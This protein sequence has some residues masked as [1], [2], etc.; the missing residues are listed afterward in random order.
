MVDEK[1]EAVEE[2]SKPAPEDAGEGVQ[3]ETISVLDRSDQIAQM[4]KRENDRREAILTREEELQARKAVGGET[5]A[6]Q[7][8]PVISEDQKKIDNAVEYFK[9][10]QLEIDLKRA[11]E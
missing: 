1:K 7:Q 3:S 5:E 4:Q 6:G 11:N 9:G 2:V 10:T 8:A